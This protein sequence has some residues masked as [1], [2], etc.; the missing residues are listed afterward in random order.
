MAE[1]QDPATLQN[2]VLSESLRLSQ[3]LSGEPG[4]AKILQEVG[5]SIKEALGYQVIVL[6]IY[7]NDIGA[8]KPLWMES[9]D[10][11]T[12]TELLTSPNPLIRTQ[13]LTEDFLR[14]GSYII[15][16]DH[17]V[18][19]GMKASRYLPG[20]GEE[21]LDGRGDVILTPILSSGT[22][23][24]GLIM[25]VVKDAEKEAD[26]VKYLSYFSRLAGCALERG[27]LYLQREENSN[28]NRILIQTVEKLEKVSDPGQFWRTIAENIGTAL[29]GFE[30][31]VSI[32]NQE[33]S[34]YVHPLVLR[35][36][37]QMDGL[38]SVDGAWLGRVAEQGP[39]TELIT[40][41]PE[42]PAVIKM[43]WPL[44]I[45]KESLGVL[46]VTGLNSG[47][48]DRPTAD[49]LGMLATQ[50]ALALFRVRSVDEWTS[51]KEVLEAYIKN[52]DDAVLIVDS[53]K[54][55]VFVNNSAQQLTDLRQGGIDKLPLN[56]NDKEWLSTALD[57]VSKGATKEAEKKIIIKDSYC[58]IGIKGFFDS[59]KYTGSIIK[60]H[61]LKQE[62]LEYFKELAGM[63]AALE[64]VELLPQIL[65][66]AVRH[67]VDFDAGSILFR[68][69]GDSFRF[70]ASQGA[71]IDHDPDM[72]FNLVTGLAEAAINE[73]RTLGLAGKE[74]SLAEGLGISGMGKPLA[75][76]SSVLVTP[77]IFKG[78][79]TG[80]MVLSKKDQ[81]AY[82]E[83]NV[84][85]IDE[86]STG[87]SKILWQIGVAGKL[88]QENALR[89]K[90]YEIGFASGSVLQVGSLLN[91][92]IRT[93]AKELKIDE[94]GIY[95][96]DEVLG[97]WNGKA[98]QSTGKNGGFLELMKSSGIKLDYERLSEIKEITATVIA[99]GEPEIVPDLK[100]DPRFLSAGQYQGLRSGLWLPLKL[101]DK[102]IGAI[103][104]LSKQ[105]SYF[106]HDDLTL[107]QELSPLVTFALRS[108]VLYEEI[109]RE[110]SR[111]GAII[112][113]M[114]EG[115]L[116]VDSHFKVIMSNEGFEGLWGLKQT[117]RP[118]AAL[119]E[120]ILS[121]LTNNLANPRGL[122]D[123]FQDCAISTTGVVAP[124]ELELKNGKHLKISSFPVEELDR[125]RTGLVI[126]SQD[127]TT[128]HQIAELRQEFVGM[129]S[130]DLRNPLAAIIATL[131]L[132]LDGS[133]GELNENQNQFL[134]NAM[135][136]S[137]RMLEMLN[138]FLD[139]YKYDAVEIKLE[140]TNFDIAQL[141]S[142]LV[143][144]FSPLA[145]ERN[146]ELLQETPPTITITGDEGKLARVISNLLS[147][148]LKFTPR[149]GGI[150]LKSAERT[151]SIEI[152]VSDTGEGISA[153]DKDKVFEKF[154]QVEKRRHGRKTG[155]GLGLPLCK[156]LVEAHGGK[157]WVESQ[158]GKGSRFI[159]SLPR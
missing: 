71:M 115:L 133:L 108:A 146:I 76:A 130:H 57:D 123:F 90:L 10:P 46:T 141:I 73:G 142:R 105:I 65:L 21:A 63:V 134:G 93:I 77:L 42:K 41:H 52:I 83:T 49:F 109:R 159:F 158:V 64:D 112:N 82:P 3:A 45:E 40:V 75:G 119:Q 117:I 127:I 91:L 74:G 47:E 39:Q 19:E 62:G 121:L 24:I 148:A 5:R 9:V 137:R 138:D 104:A 147:N 155:T 37:K 36:G 128:E 122:I 22:A 30:L 61:S 150:I 145:R 2:K 68:E 100:S 27:L 113:S 151:D 12:G 53:I 28:F 8:F 129:L 88:K 11:D 97:E 135:N 120:G 84:A 136:D 72:T 60:I 132:A 149:G 14:S 20:L 50:I 156:K 4:P 143:A 25:V 56:Q 6:S 98:I 18:W 66:K 102:P 125:P 101:K 99:R 94:M 87:L 81:A 43:G 44:E 34:Y 139:G 17:P 131:E 31:V 16:A 116:M 23:M 86:L 7:E 114:P 106:G 55:I 38:T 67:F 153:E 33:G 32:A 35:D 69:R 126:L 29:K 140:K 59:K 13:L 51:R 118:G 1:R 124:V 103:S 70:L 96:F 111:V 110:G 48:L 92:M 152:A 54:R 95:F 15:K 79:N 80:L 107:L 58:S 26:Q 157:I 144:D 85:M 154:Y 78:Q 89:T